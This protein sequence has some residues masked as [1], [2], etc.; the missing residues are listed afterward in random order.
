MAGSGVMSD[1]YRQ[2]LE[3]GPTSLG[4]GKSWRKVSNGLL[5][6]TTS[7]GPEQT[8]VGHTESIQALMEVIRL[9]KL[10]VNDRIQRESH[11]QDL[12]FSTQKASPRSSA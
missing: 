8:S 3:E 9:R 7:L 5:A 1:D 11:R 2:D 12:L 10:T 4:F 6:R